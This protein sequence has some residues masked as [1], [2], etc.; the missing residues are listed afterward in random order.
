MHRRVHFSC[1]GCRSSA[2]IFDE[3]NDDN[4][5]LDINHHIFLAYKG[6][7]KNEEYSKRHTSN[8]I[9]KWLQ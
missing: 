8:D 2:V 6:V 1:I 7:T 3:V 4:Y 9:S 5:S